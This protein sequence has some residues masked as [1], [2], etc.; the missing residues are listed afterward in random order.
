ML[1]S[2][3]PGGRGSNKNTPPKRWAVIWTE[4]GM[5][6]A[7][8]S[9]FDPGREGA[10]RAPALIMSKIFLPMSLL[11]LKR[12][13]QAS[14]PE[15]KQKRST[16]QVFHWQQTRHSPPRLATSCSTPLSAG[17]CPAAF[18]EAP[19]L[20]V[21]CTTDQCSSCTFP[22]AAEPAHTFPLSCPFL[23]LTCTGPP[24]RSDG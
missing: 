23:P 3:Q 8:A 21:S 2:W 17:S 7:N 24:D 9:C 11:Q 15:N 14:L 18:P 22:S 1:T 6:L 4:K 19:L 16:V 13:K 5:L 12:S 20:P 10:A